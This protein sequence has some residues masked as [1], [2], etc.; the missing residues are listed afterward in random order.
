MVKKFVAFLVI[1]ILVSVVLFA[2]STFVGNDSA[3]VGN[4]KLGPLAD[5]GSSTGNIK[6][7]NAQLLYFEEA[8]EDQVN[9]D[10]DYYDLAIDL[11]L[12]SC[13]KDGN[14]L[15][16][17]DSFTSQT[18]YRVSD[19]CLNSN[20]LIEYICDSDARGMNLAGVDVE[21]KSCD[22]GCSSISCD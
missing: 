20:Y 5:I 15:V 22:N 16:F 12:D 18:V 14:Y 17:L 3:L 2:V 8:L 13:V 4:A 1:T 10:L 19:T 9:Y 7:G 21:I 6:L 11:E